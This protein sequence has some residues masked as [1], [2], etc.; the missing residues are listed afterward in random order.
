MKRAAEFITRHSR[1]ILIV[2]IVIAIGCAALIPQ[3]NVNTDMTKYLPS[4]SSMRMGLDILEE[5]FESSDS[6]QVIRVMFKDLDEEEKV[7]MPGRLS[8]IEYVDSVSYDP[9]SEDY[10]NGSYTLYVINM[11]YA[12]G[13]DEEYFIEDALDTGFAEHDMTYKDGAIST[14]KLPVRVIVVAIILLLIIL[15]IMSNSW[16]E[17]FLIVVTIGIAVLIN[18]GTNIMRDSIARVTSSIGWILQLIL[19]MDYAIIL[20][21][22]YRQEYSLSNDRETALRSA[23]VKAFPSVTGSGL[24]TVIGL[25]ML[26]FMSFRIGFDMGFVLAKGVFISMICTFTVMPGLILI[27]SDMIMKTGKKVPQIPFW[28]L[29]GGLYRVRRAVIPGFLILFIAVMFF[30]NRTEI[31]YVLGGDS[32]IEDIFPSENSIVMVYN[33]EDEDN[34]ESFVEGLGDND[35]I[36]SVISYPTVLARQYSAGDMADSIGSLTDEIEIT[37]SLAQMIYYDYYC[38]DDV[39]DITVGEF[40]RFLSDYIISDDSFSGYFSDDIT[41]SI[42]MMLRFSDPETLAEPMNAD[43]LSELF[44]TDADDISTLLMLYYMVNGGGS[45]GSMTL[46]EFAD[47]A[48]N[49][50]ASDETWPSFLD[51]DTLNLL[52]TLLTYTDSSA[53]TAPRSYKSMADL[54]GMDAD[55]IKLLYVYYYFMQS[56]Y[57]PTSMTVPEF[58]SFLNNDV[59]G[60]PSFSSMIDSGTASLLSLLSVYTD[61]DLI[62]S[63]AEY[64]KMAGIVGTD[65]VTARLIYALYYYSQD[66]YEPGELTLSGF[67]DFILND[68]GPDL[69]GLGLFDENLAASVLALS[70][71]TDTSEITASMTAQELAE[72]FGMD[73]DSVSAVLFLRSLLTGAG[74]SSELSPY[75]FVDFIVEAADGSDYLAAYLD[76]DLLSELSFV[77]TVMEASVS[78]A[79]YGPSEITDLLGLENYGITEDTVRMLYAYNDA[80]TQS[81]KISPAD[82]IGFLVS[83][84]TGDFGYMSFLSGDTAAEIELLN[85]IM[86]ATVNGTLYSFSLMS[87]FLGMDSDLTKLIYTYHDFQ[88]NTGSWSISAQTALNFVV[89][90]SAVMGSL[91][92][93]DLSAVATAQKIVNASVAGT[94]FTYEELAGLL[95]IDS[96]LS[97]VVYL[98]HMNMRGDTSEWMISPSAFIDFMTE[99]I[100]SDEDTSGMIEEETAGLIL[101]LDVIVDDVIS[102]KALDPGKM[103]GLIIDLYPGIDEDITDIIYLYYSGIFEY[104]PGWSL[105]IEELVGFLA[106]D[107]VYDTRFDMFFTD[108]IKEEILS[109]AEEIYADIAMLKSDNYSLLTISTRYPDESDETTAF[110][111]SLNELGEKYL[112]KDF[113]LVGNSPMVYEMENGFDRELVVV[114]L[115]TAI[116]IFIVVA[117]SFRSFVIPLLLVLVVQCGVYITVSVCGLAG[118]SI[119]YLAL[120]I[121]QCILMGATIDYGILYTNCYR[122]ARQSL[123]VMEAASEAY[124]RSGHTILTSGLIMVIVTAVIAVSPADPTICQICMTVSIGVAAAIIL[125]TLLLPGMLM[126]ADRFAVKKRKD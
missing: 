31:S 85:D 115:L 34:I 32:E 88:K 35:N 80:G 68:A 72:F 14:M 41:E 48:A 64:D 7:S 50:L 6:S 8:G 95:E 126:M 30:Q 91:N 124:R 114:T 52:D 81:W 66:D 112:D 21:N 82:L 117:V 86:T 92:G 44:G 61:A 69:S 125:I 25:L 123:P 22:R 42:D 121:V 70:A 57:T 79:V 98:I 11:D 46:S 102:E 87:S 104:D 107:V 96:E 39:P 122:E 36:N 83:G 15:V 119:Y 20:M 19:S 93:N 111:E 4:D 89:S 33:N 120:L 28:H 43:K 84:D 110:I 63:P 9:D 71:Y 59:A 67:A 58:V 62:T 113:Y 23:L 53:M 38:G 65:T 78:G 24:T 12:Y 54:L 40:V 101:T 73:E 37:D 45:T 55:E 27:F 13:S 10:N 5:Q 116:S 74:A 49:D 103:A 60:D 2:M 118:F 26:V 76:D 3:V 106:E 108:E 56:G 97:R 99:E 90:N 77:R 51:D 105:S 75:E 100:L 17:A 16:T 18:M 47:F 109:L 1:L 94:E 29:S